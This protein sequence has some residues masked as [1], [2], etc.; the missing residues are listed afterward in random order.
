M[1]HDGDRGAPEDVDQE[2]AQ[3]NRELLHED[4]LLPRAGVALGRTRHKALPDVAGPL[5]PIGGVAQHLITVC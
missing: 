1:G 3:R 5:Q 4:D 2:R